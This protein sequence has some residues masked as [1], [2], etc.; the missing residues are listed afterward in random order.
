MSGS[1]PRPRCVLVLACLAFAPSLAT[2][3]SG[4]IAGRVTESASS[5]PVVGARV[6]T[7]GGP[8]RRSVSTSTDGSYRIGEL[9]AGIYAVVVS[10]LGQQPRR[11]DS[12]VV[13]AG[14]TIAVDVTLQP[15]PHMLE[16]V[17]VTSGRSPE[18]VLDAPSPIFVID[19][20][21]VASR[22]SLT[23]ADHLKGMPGVDV[24]AGGIV[25]S[26]VVARGFNNAFSGS[27]L[28]LQDYR[29]AGVPS[30]RVNVPFLFTGTNEDIERIEV[31]L[32]P[33][34]A[35][36]GPNSSSGVLHIITKSPFDSRGTTVTL[37]GGERS[38]F[39]GSLRHSAVVGEKVGF[40]ISGEYMT[41]QDWSYR[42][43]G[44]PATV[45]RGG[46][47]VS[48]DFDVNRYV[49]EA[50][51]DVRPFTDAE[52]ITT[53]GLTHV[54]SSVELTGANGA[55]QVKNWNYQ[56][57][58][59]RMR[60][61]RL[62]AQAFL[63]L[64][65]AGNKDINDAD[66]TFLLRSG[67]PIVD[68]S[69]VAAGS[70]QHSFELG[71]RQRFVYGGDYIWTNPRTG[72]TING[73]NEDDDN[74]TEYGGYLH[75][76]TKLSPKWEAV[77]AIRLDKNDRI[78][79]TFFSPRVALVFKPTKNQN[80]RATFDRAYSTPGNFSFF[81]DLVQARNIS[82]LPYDIRA[83]GVPPEGGWRY[84]QS[85][86]AS[87][88]GGYC[89]RSPFPSTLGA[90][91]TFVDANA[92]AYY[93][94]VVTALQ[95]RLP[96]SLFPILQALN[97]TS[98]QVGTV[99]R[100][101]TSTG[102]VLSP[103]ALAPIKPLE[104]TFVNNYELGYKGLIGK[105]ASLSMDGWYQQRINFVTPAQ[106][107]T[108]NVFMDPATLGPYLVVSLA[109]AL[110]AQGM[111]QAQA[112][113]TAQAAAPAITAGLAAVPVG[114]VTFDDARRA[115]NS[116]ILFTYRNVDK[117]IGLWGLDF[118]YDQA[119]ARGWSMAATYSF[120]NKGTFD[121]IDGG[122]GQPL[123][124]NAP[125]NKASL[126]AR[127]EN[128]GQRLRFEARGRYTEGFDV[129]SGVYATGVTYPTPGVAGST[130][131]YPA[132]PT[133]TLLDAGVTYKLPWSGGAASWSINGTNLTDRKVASFIGVPNIGR[134]IM[135]RLQYTF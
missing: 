118:A 21:G 60:V 101:I 90:P 94:A 42:D 32:G 31:L 83:V 26:N 76:V 46:Q 106:V 135:T 15:V 131:T 37:D 120:V 28:T 110:Q 67:Q 80:L 35:L 40:K 72:N 9:P 93:R 43:P 95:S 89:M 3:Q 103:T 11:V 1:L 53:Y 36:Y 99:L 88:A 47:N 29:F 44:E 79:G 64:S 96:A 86:D 4:A 24:S 75:S 25:Q 20:Q 17:A 56:S 123:R 92:A 114:T 69:R 98:A 133:A 6:E 13:S 117:T 121:E 68:Q 129:N 7:S 63:N 84:R 5:I 30:L 105:T 14:G 78:D 122:A 130:Y 109:Q 18:K 59:Q 19:Q 97:P 100:N 134:M 116:D 127:W 102:T 2:A 34:A 132:V 112:Q 8:A 128:Q 87:L 77:G 49:T 113:A 38:I 61:G 70:V 104:A 23:A 126:T 107:A 48:R 33:A 52:F 39:R 115:N 54:G 111:S 108:P 55:A 124:L 81:L 12:V 91:Q 65:D 82:G 58:Q 66:G 125:T 71:E 74:V 73:R 27:L 10:R 16:Q 85:C 57:I 22:P 62:F 45:S 119:L 51:M 50:R 41:G